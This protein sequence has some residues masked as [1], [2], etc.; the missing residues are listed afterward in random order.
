MGPAFVVHSSTENSIRF[1]FLIPQVESYFVLSSVYVG[2]NSIFNRTR[3]ALGTLI[4][5]LI[6]V[7]LIRPIISR[8]L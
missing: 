8:H 5:A 4:M 2:H 6:L 3:A 1:Y 7:C